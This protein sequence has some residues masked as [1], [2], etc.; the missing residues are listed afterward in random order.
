[1]AR[2]KTLQ[3]DFDFTEIATVIRSVDTAVT[4][5]V[6]R[7]IGRRTIVQMKRMIARG[8]SPIRGGGLKARF[9]GYIAVVRGQKA[10][11]IAKSLTG[12][13]KRRA[14]QI[15]SR[16][17]GYPFNRQKDFPSKGLRPVNLK[18][19][20]DFMRDLTFKVQ[21]QGMTRST[22]IGFYSADSIDKELG[23][24][25]GANGQPRR[26]IIPTLREKFAKTIRLAQEQIYE[27]AVVKFLII[28][29]NKKIE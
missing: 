12:A 13:R 14:K 25:V 22:R 19:S 24:R 7:G 10:R 29:L 5:N 15:A 26:P 18:L 9:P 1:L 21:R 2:K 11:K 8:I 4:E 23:H 16:K 17:S 6:A 28:K 3:F 20:G 27:G